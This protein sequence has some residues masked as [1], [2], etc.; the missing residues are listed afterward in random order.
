MPIAPATHLVSDIIT[1]AKRQ[2]GDESGAQITDTDIIRWV[3][4]GQLEIARKNK[5]N[6]TTATTPSVSGQSQ[7][8]FT[9]VNIISI[10]AVFYNEVPIDQ[11]QFSEVQ[12]LI[13]SKTNPAQT[14]SGVPI[15]W[16]D[17]DDS[18]FLWPPPQASTDTIKLF[19]VLQPVLI[20]T[21]SD[22][23]SIPDVYYQSLLNY[24]MQQ[25]YELD[26]DWNGSMVK[27]KQLTDDLNEI[28]QDYGSERFYATITVMQEDA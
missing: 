27:Q 20:T 22:T 16:Y 14:Q 17:W 4:Q 3:N 11:R 6:K 21:G 7:Y 2:F 19:C 1:A 13:L 26:D 18:V 24:V 28:E 10:E 25:A 5:W 9:G 12:E 23:L 8:S 15:L